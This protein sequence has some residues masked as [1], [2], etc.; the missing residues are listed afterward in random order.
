MVILLACGRPT[1]QG[2]VTTWSHLTRTYDGLWNAIRS[3]HL[4]EVSIPVIGAG[5]SRI[6]L[7]HAAVLLA[8]LLSFHA[9]NTERPVC[10]R[11][12]V[13][14]PPDEIDQDELVRARRFLAALNYSIR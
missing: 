10:Q 13:V 8:L 12:R 2:T 11:L 4:D 5:F 1:D 3:H 9:A 14:I 7:S 6:N